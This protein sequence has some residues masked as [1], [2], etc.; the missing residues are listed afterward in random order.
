[1]VTAATLLTAF[2][3]FL[4]GDDDGYFLLSLRGV[5]N[6]HALFTET[7]SQYGPAYF[8]IVGGLFR[9]LSL[10]LTLDNARLLPAICTIVTATLLAVVA[11]RLTRSNRLSIVT[12]VATAIMAPLEAAIHPSFLIILLVAV[13]ALTAATGPVTVYRATLAGGIVGTL[14]MVKVNVGVLVAAALLAAWISDRRILRVQ[15]RSIVIAAIPCGFLIL[16]MRQQHSVTLVAGLALAGLAV[17]LTSHRSTARDSVPAPA[18]FFSAAAAVAAWSAYALVSG[19]SARD[20]VRG[21]LLD[22]L[23]QADAFAFDFHVTVTR[24]P[25]AIACV[26]GAVWLGTEQGGRVL[27][28]KPLV[29]GLVRVGGGAVLLGCCILLRFPRVEDSLPI[30]AL[31]LGAALAWILLL[32]RHVGDGLD[33]GRFLICALAT[34]LPL[35]A[36]P[37]AGG[38]RSV[39]ATLFGLIGCLMV[40]D[41]VTD[42]RSWEVAPRRVG[43]ERILLSGA[44]AVF[45]AAA[46][47]WAVLSARHFVNA[48]PMSLPGAQRL[49]T[50]PP[51]GE[52]LRRVTARLDSC[53]AF[54]SMPGMGSFHLLTGQDPPTWHNA[55]HWMTLFSASTQRLVVRDLARHQD[56]CVVRNRSSEDFW[57]AHGTERPGPLRAFL[58][59]GAYDRS[60][61]GLYEV[62]RISPSTPAAAP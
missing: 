61:H 44:T 5:T 12:F 41:G 29:S 36:Y 49:R 1:M 42:L 51:L 38:Q 48:A 39:G 9:V 52:D 23:R 32:P 19:T 43:L 10:P 11:F 13:L 46:L 45:V 7:Y 60:E 55:G 17:A 34:L 2:T 40:F 3:G 21:V 31:V 57:L 4:S 22:P 59:E 25:I 18:A 15:L 53:A 30:D 54:Y 28:L 33:R 35:Q 47:G 27:R 16:S 50:W 20:L 58:T 8:G 6:G 14:L 24:I 56:L 26:A 37:A 62:Y